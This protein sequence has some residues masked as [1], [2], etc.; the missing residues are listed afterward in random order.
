MKTFE[1]AQQAGVVNM[2][3]HAAPANWVSST[4]PDTNVHLGET[5]DLVLTAPTTG[6][7]FILRCPN[8]TSLHELNE[9][10][11]ELMSFASPQL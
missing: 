5:V 8:P 6:R 3:E 7:R 10:A 11:G 4:L 1:Q 2:V 9:V